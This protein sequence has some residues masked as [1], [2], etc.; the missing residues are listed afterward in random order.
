MPRVSA[1]LVL[2]VLLVLP[3]QSFAQETR[4]IVKFNAGRSEAGRAALR[5]AGGQV[6]V[7]LDPQNAVAARLPAQALA[8]LSRNPNIEYIEVDAVRRP[9]ATWNDRVLSSGEVLPFGVQMV[10][11]DRVR[12]TNVEA[13]KVCII[14]SGYSEQHLDLRDDTDDL[15]TQNAS[16]ARAGS[17]N[18]DSCG[19]GTHVAGTVLA[20]SGNDFGVIGVAD[21]VRLHVVKVFG[22]D[23]LAGQSCSWTY[24]SALVD[25]L[26]KCEAAGATIV[27]MSLGGST[28]SRTEDS[29]FAAAYRRG[30]LHIAAAGNDGDRSTSYPAGYASVVSVAAVDA[31][32]NVASFSQRNKDV[33][34]AAPGEGVLSTVPWIDENTLTLPDA[35]TLAGGHV[36]FAARTASVTG[37]LVDGGLCDRAGAWGGSVVLCQRGSISF[38]DKVSNVQAGGGVAAVIYNNSA[39]DPTCGDFTGTLGEGNSSTIPAITLSCAEGSQARGFTGAA[40]TVRSQITVPASGYEAWNGTSMATPHVSGVAALLWSCYPL[41]TNQQIRDTLN[42]TARDKGAPGRDTSYGF[43][44]VQTKAA[45][46]SLGGSP[47]CAT[48]GASKY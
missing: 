39:S 26:N 16:D 4:Y 17:W 9:L 32:E 23:D 11:A 40:A 34:I 48:F 7:A 20:T 22:N 18:R 46:D 6:L 15:I 24:S 21:G 28:R 42:A 30:L 38:F 12:S 3:L 5:A 45:I 27:S 33:E 29:A 25:A 41:R 37:G 47:Y 14:D 2:F 13:K 36:E 43:G 31:N 19:H 8:G 10:Q 1:A 44:I 35:S